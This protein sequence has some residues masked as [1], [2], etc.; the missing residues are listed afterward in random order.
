MGTSS[1]WKISIP[2]VKPNL[3]L[4]GT[5]KGEETYKLQMGVSNQTQGKWGNG[6]LQ[7]EICCQG[8]FFKHKGSILIKT[9]ALMVKFVSIRT[10]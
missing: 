7:G 4:G 1:D 9:Y 3:E 5:T 2:H 8:V 10:I 6:S